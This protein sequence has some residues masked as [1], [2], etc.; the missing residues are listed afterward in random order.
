M[1]SAHPWRSAAVRFQ[2]F[3]ES[4]EIC[5]CNFFRRMGSRFPRWEMGVDE[6]EVTPLCRFG[7]HNFHGGMHFNTLIS[8]IQKKLSP[9]ILKVASVVLRTTSHCG[10]HTRACSKISESE[11]SHQSF[12]YIFYSST[13]KSTGCPVLFLL[14][15]SCASRDRRRDQ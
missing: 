2:C 10:P 5:F 15:S 1:A 4:S 14:N 3:G 6:M 12:Y 11:L 7:R 13:K 8:I 9:L